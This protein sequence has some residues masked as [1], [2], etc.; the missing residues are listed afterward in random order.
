MRFGYSEDLS[1]FAPSTSSSR[2]STLLPSRFRVTVPVFLSTL[3]SVVNA[4]QPY[5]S[6]GEIGKSRHKPFA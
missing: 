6:P 3:L 4:R 2:S 5:D 1:P